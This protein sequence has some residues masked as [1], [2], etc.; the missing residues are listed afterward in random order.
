[1]NGRSDTAIS[2]TP[3]SSRELVRSLLRVLPMA[4]VVAVLAAVVAAGIAAAVSSTVPVKY[5]AAAQFN[6]I[7]RSADIDAI[8]LSRGIVAE[9]VLRHLK[10]GRADEYAAAAAPKDKYTAEWVSGPGFGEISYKV[11]SDDPEVARAAAQAVYDN[12]GFLGF[13]LPRPDAAPSVLD[14]VA[15]KAPAPTRQSSAKTIAAAAVF[16]GF[17]GFALTLLFAVPMRRPRT[18]P[19]GRTG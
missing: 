2:T 19:S 17:A 5:A 10:D 6:V 4:L 14:L 12:A 7:A 8:S 1:M 18:A 13:N 3:Q 11:V 16:G 9:Q 15:V